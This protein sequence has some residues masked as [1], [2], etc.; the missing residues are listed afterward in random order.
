[1][2][3]TAPTMIIVVYG[4]LFLIL[5]MA[6]NILKKPIF[7]NSSITYQLFLS[8]KPLK[9]LKWI[10]SSHTY[11]QV[12]FKFLLAFPAGI[13]E[14]SQPGL[15]DPD[16]YSAC[17]KNTPH[18]LFAKEPLHE[19]K[20]VESETSWLKSQRSENLNHGIWSRSGKWR[21]SVNSDKF[22]F[23]GLQNHCRQ[24]PQ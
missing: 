23:L 2:L 10:P 11:T 17:P 12:E 24:W 20:R 5:V 3:K 16:N 15:F 22:N 18:I 19:G 1:M 21:K 4:S 9:K 13:S 8:Y 14:R 7:A 6:L